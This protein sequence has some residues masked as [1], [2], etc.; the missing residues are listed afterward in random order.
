MQCSPYQEKT[1][2]WLFLPPYSVLSQVE[3]SLELLVCPNRTTSLFYVVLGNSW[4][5]Q[6]HHLPQVGDLGTSPS[7]SN[8]NSWGVRCLDKL[9]PWRSW[10]CAF[11]VGVSKGEIV[12]NML[13]SSF[14]LLGES[15]SAPKCKLIRSRQLK[16]QL[17]EY[18]VI[19]LPGRNWETKMG[20]LPAPS[21]LSPGG[22]ASAT[23][24]VLI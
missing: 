1:R 11:T 21:V 23:A 18:R 13:T 22:I 16:Q 24:C 15:Q 14:R 17:E 8:C 20:I 12:G 5:V 9:F 4:N 10:R 19:F 2:C 6:P 7:G 3:Q